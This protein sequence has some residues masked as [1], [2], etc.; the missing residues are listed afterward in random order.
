MRLLILITIAF[1][2]L[3]A[4]GRSARR[5]SHLR[6]CAWL[7]QSLFAYLL[8]AYLAGIMFWA[9]DDSNAIAWLV[10]SSVVVFVG[11][12]FWYRWAKARVECYDI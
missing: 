11:Y 1:V 3:L 4:G 8:I 5:R 7:A 2:L 12:I 10:G 9:P 6:V